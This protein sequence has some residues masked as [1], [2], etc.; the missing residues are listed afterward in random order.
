MTFLSFLQE[1][2]FDAIGSLSNLITFTRKVLNFP[3]I[4]KISF[5]PGL[6]SIDYESFGKLIKS[7]PNLDTVE[8]ISSNKNHHVALTEAVYN[9]CPVLEALSLITVI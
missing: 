5:K 3:Q 4:Q 8:I 7:C 9:S 1:I 6:T 2:D